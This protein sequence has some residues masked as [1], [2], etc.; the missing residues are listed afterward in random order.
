[1]GVQ[2][3]TE[4]LCAQGSLHWFPY[5]ESLGALGAVFLSFLRSHVNIFKMTKIGQEDEID[6]VDSA[7]RGK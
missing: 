7:D 5:S 6:R 4:L 1:M 3:S 2:I